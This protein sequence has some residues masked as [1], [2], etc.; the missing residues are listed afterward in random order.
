[1]LL[2]SINYWSFPGGLEGELD[3]VQFM[4]QSKDCGFDCVELAIGDSGSCLSIDATE[5]QCQAILAEAAKLGVTVGSLASGLYWT[6]N[7][8]DPETG[9]QARDDLE[10]MLVIT[11][12]LGARTLLT[13]PGAVDVFFMPERPMQPYAQVWQHATDGLRAVLPTA[14]RVDVRI[15]IENVWNKFLMSPQ[16]MAS[17]IDQFQSPY[18]G[19]YVDVA[20]LLPFGSAQDWLRHLGH[21]V[22]GVHFKDFRKSVGTVDGFVDLLE[23]D[24]DWP[25][26]VHALREIGYAGPVAA[27]MIPCY[28]HHPIIRIQNTSRAMDAILH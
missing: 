6:R 9:I 16:E 14:E 25:E 23:G 27:E 24:V 4:V 20:N 15:G 10:K 26:V 5:T 13:I 19:A 28:R 17:F 3:P 12:W 8:A 11:H 21:R 7:L 1:M 2:K 18:I 22:V